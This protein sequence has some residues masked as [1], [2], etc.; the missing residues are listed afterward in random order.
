M[1]YGLHS[2]GIWP[3]T[4][5]VPPFYSLSCVIPGAKRKPMNFDFSVWL[6][7]KLTS[8]VAGRDPVG[9]RDTQPV[10]AC[11]TRA[12]PVDARVYDLRI[13][14]EAAWRVRGQGIRALRNRVLR[15]KL[16][17]I[18][19]EGGSEHTANLARTASVW[20]LLNRITFLPTAR[21]LGHRS[22]PSPP[23]SARHLP[24]LQVRVVQDLLSILRFSVSSSRAKHTAIE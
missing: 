21:V 10:L 24:L 15:R 1:I 13:L 3:T 23:S 14:D 11:T 19:H 22:H 4:R 16:V 7:V 9:M 5:A 8:L 2:R 6:L 12:L 20:A 18:W 17:R